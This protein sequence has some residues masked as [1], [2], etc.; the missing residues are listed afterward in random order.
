MM[1]KADQILLSAIFRCGCKIYAGSTKEAIPA[2]VG[3][4]GNN[5]GLEISVLCRN[6][7]FRRKPYLCT[8]KNFRLITGAPY[9]KTQTGKEPDEITRG[10]KT[11]N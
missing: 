6:K 7:L 8:L 1:M 4:I 11:L 9:L 10:N 5:Q 2:I 3:L